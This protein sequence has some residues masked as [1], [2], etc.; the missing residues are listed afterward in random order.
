M[1]D[2]VNIAL[3]ELSGDLA[4]ALAYWRSLG[5]DDCVCTWQMFDLMKIPSRVIPTTMVIDIFDDIEN[6]VFR[7]WG[8]GMTRIHGK[9][10]T[11]KS[12]YQV[13]PLEFSAT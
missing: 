7:Y 4:D 13:P 12:P 5:G 8:S 10:M 6:N 3:D 2:K 1:T 9:D 11:G